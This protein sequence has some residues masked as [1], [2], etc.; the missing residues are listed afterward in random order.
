MLAP[1]LISLLTIK[2]RKKKK[3]QDKQTWILTY[4][5]TNSTAMEIA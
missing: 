2:K 1:S 4:I 5:Q 3:I